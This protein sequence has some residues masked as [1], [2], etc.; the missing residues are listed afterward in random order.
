MWTDG[1]QLWGTGSI[2]NIEIIQRYQSKILRMITRAP[3]YISNDQIHK[4]LN[5]PTVNEEVQNIISN[6]K[7][8]ISNHPKPTMSGL[9]S[10]TFGRLK[11]RTIQN[12]N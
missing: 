6:Y 12:F 10:H 11:R 9:L 8:R 3:W 5:I 2:K 1:A 4:D 7:L